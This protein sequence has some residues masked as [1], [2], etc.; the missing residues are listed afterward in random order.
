[1]DLPAGVLTE[2]IEASLNS[3]IR[4][5]DD[6]N[7]VDNCLLKVTDYGCRINAASTVVDESSVLTV[8]LQSV[9]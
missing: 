8:P 9:L 2:V 7:G 1:M 4:S 6:S 5:K 3:Y